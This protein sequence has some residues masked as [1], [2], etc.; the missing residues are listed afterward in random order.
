M[1]YLNLD[2]LARLVSIIKSK[3]D[4]LA[5]SVSTNVAD[6]D[7]IN[8]KIPAQASAS[9]PLAD[10]SFVNSSV[11]TNTANF[12][13]TFDSVDALNA[14]SG[15]KTNND[16]AF[17]QSKDAA[18]NTLFKRYKWNGSAWLYEYELNNS[19]FTAA[20]W[21]AVN[22]GITAGMIPSGASSTD[23][24]T[25]KSQVAMLGSDGSVALAGG[26][27][28]AKNAL[29]K[30]QAFFETVDDMVVGH[31]KPPRKFCDMEDAA[32]S[33]L[34]SG[35]YMAHGNDESGGIIVGGDGIDEWAPPDNELHRFWNEDE[36]Q[37]V[38]AVSGE[39]EFKGVATT[40]RMRQVKLFQSWATL[41][42]YINQLKAK[43]KS[44]SDTV[45]PNIDGRT[46]GDG[47]YGIDVACFVQ[48]TDGPPSSDYS[49]Y[50]VETKMIVLANGT[51]YFGMQVAWGV[52]AGT[53]RSA[54]RR[55]YQNAWGNWG[56]NDL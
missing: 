32:Y 29:F 20:Q 7:A 10:K 11:A 38:A 5:S 2:G 51:S 53:T 1:K 54:Y 27:E 23:P 40:A 3:L 25:K 48:G 21:A 15:A 47:Y 49:A 4:E 9:N 55:F 35:A 45:V 19:S 33:T 44:D 17:V 34:V 42:N 46:A 26:L 24:L 41:D 50:F 56:S 43:L 36:C 16:Y 8:A 6:I 22:S 13:G 37:P 52:T 30:Q 28:V 12:I 18:G 31:G 14:Y 39:G